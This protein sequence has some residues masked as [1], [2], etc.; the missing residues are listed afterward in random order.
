MKFP[1]RGRPSVTNLSSFEFGP[2]RNNQSQTL[3]GL[4]RPCFTSMARKE[5]ILGVDHKT[6]FFIGEGVGSE[7]FYNKIN[8]ASIVLP[9]KKKY[10]YSHCRKK[11]KFTHAQWPKNAGYTKQKCH[12]RLEKRNSEWMKGLKTNRTFN[13]ITQP[14]SKTVY[15][16]LRREFASLKVV[17]PYDTYFPFNGVNDVDDDDAWEI[18][19]FSQCGPFNENSVNSG[20]KIK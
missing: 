13:L 19:H 5:A 2:E 4:R 6:Y 17:F 16:S 14:N 18:Q 3:I 10:A 7:R 15:S 12:T 9:K 20:K 11:K 8:P 1:C